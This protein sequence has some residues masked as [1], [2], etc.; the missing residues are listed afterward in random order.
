VTGFREHG[1]E[2]SDSAEGGEFLDK[3]SNFYLFKS[4]LER[5]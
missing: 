5:H 4:K 2:P 3:L 1:N